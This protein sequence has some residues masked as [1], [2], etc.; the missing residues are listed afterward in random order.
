MQ[1]RATSLGYY[2]HRRQREGDVFT[3]KP[4]TVIERSPNG[5]I[6]KDENGKP[7]KKLVTPEMQF[8]EKW[9]ERLGDVKVS[10][11]KSE[12]RE[13]KALSEVDETEVPL[14]EGSEGS[15]I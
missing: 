2:N 1:V 4:Y 6:I 15:P 10:K 3:L 9:M 11:R 13:P 14:E 8:S 7:K 12:H 5:A